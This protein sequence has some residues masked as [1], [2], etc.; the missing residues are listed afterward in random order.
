M[1]PGSARVAVALA[2][3]TGALATG[4]CTGTEK[5][6]VGADI[7]P[8]GI[9]DGGLRSIVVDDLARATDYRIFPSARAFGDR[10][11]VA[12]GWPAEPGVESRALMLFDLSVAAIPAEEA[13]LAAE[14][15]VT[16]VET[17]EAPVTVAV[18]R[19]TS[20]WESEAASWTRRTFG[21]DWETPG[22]D[23]DPVPAARFEID[24]DAGEELRFE[25]PPD[26][27]EGWR[28]G[29]FENHGVI[30][31]QETVGARFSVDTREGAPVGPLLRLTIGEPGA[32]GGT[33]APPVPTIE[34]TFVSRD[35]AGLFDENGGL[36]VTSGGPIHRTFLEFS[37]DEIPS[38]TTV[39]SAKLVMTVVRTRVPE[40]TFSVVPLEAQSGFLGEK[41]VLSPPNPTTFLGIVSIHE[42]VEPGD[43]VEFSATRL[44]GV[45][46][47]WVRNPETNMGI[48]LLVVGEELE[49]G[50]VE[51]HG[52]D[53]PE[54]LRPRLEIL[55][56]P[57]AGGGGP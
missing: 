4:A 44:S 10:M 22:G 28:S 7:L 9:L 27:V 46:Q 13:V 24:P 45:V 39:A 56:L 53:A 17:P 57:P 12:H 42:G 36:L 41:T 20:A 43:E 35:E 2:V 30:L 8:G 6:P 14:I 32:E 51:F 5:G 16:L 25:I 50:G 37:L 21:S 40:D 18:H 11:I 29:E 48:A 23:F 34:D 47:L 38:S 54:G 26:L 15:Q 49:F 31:V 3:L 52:P 33:A 1:R 55:A 19:V